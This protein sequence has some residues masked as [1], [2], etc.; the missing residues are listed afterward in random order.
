MTGSLSHGFLHWLGLGLL[1]CA[2][3]LAARPFYDI[4]NFMPKSIRDIPKKRGRGRPKTTGRGEGVLLRL[5]QPQIE[6]IDQWIVRQDND[7]SRPE[8]IRR[9]L[10]IALA[11]EG[12]AQKSGKQGAR[13]ALDLAEQEVERV[14]NKSLPA[15]EQAQRKRA[16]IRGPKEFRDI[17]GDQPVK[18]R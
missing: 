14:S 8:A 16:L 9:L 5:H 17:R 7:F 10:A 18:K 11:S 6:A 13:K 15:E 12:R 1:W 4:P 2:T 3:T